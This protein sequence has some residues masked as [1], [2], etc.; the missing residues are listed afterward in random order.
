MLKFPTHF[1]RYTQIIKD[2][3]FD[4]LEMYLFNAH[5]VLC[6]FFRN[7]VDIHEFVQAYMYGME[8][9]QNIFNDHP[10]YHEQ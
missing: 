2:L 10:P 4:D 7:I 3:P 9:V 6:V 5:L 1:I 8:N